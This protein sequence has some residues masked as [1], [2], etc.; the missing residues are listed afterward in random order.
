MRPTR[1]LLSLLSLVA[2]L[3][4]NQP[5]L[6][7]D[8]EDDPEEYEVTAR[9]ARIS[10]LKGTA[11]LRRDGDTEWEP[12]AINFPLVEGDTVA[13]ARESQ[14]E[15]QLDARNFI[16]LSAESALK[17]VTLR[18]EGV[19]LS[20][21]SGTVSLRLAALEEGRQFF[22]VDAPK[23]TLAAE[24]T[25]LYRVDVSPRGLVKVTVRGGGRARI[26]SETSGFTLREGR[27]A[28]L[29]T[30][31][32]N[33]GDWNLLAAGAPDL[34]DVWVEER[35]QYLAQHQRFDTQYHDPYVWGSEDLDSYGA[36]NY[37]TDYGWLWRPH[38]SSISGYQ[39][40]APYRFGN[41]V[42]CPPYGWT[43]VGYEPWGWAPYHYGRWVYYNNHWAWCPR[44]SYYRQ[45]SWW[46]PALVA[47]NISF[48]DNIYWYPLSYHHRDP[49]ARSRHREHSP[50][51]RPD[52]HSLWR[53][54]PGSAL[55]VEACKLAVS[56]IVV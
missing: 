31:G 28:E 24:R 27:A 25:G 4:L 29:L 26:Y 12:A 30:G 10:H 21:V 22:E 3:L 46:R 44:S 5:T 32:E 49:H 11:N 15:I 16:R 2:F 42:W 48:G 36:W 14:I 40:W 45:R 7:S 19:A 8:S 9:V 47:F 55:S 38:A 34:W 50:R 41:W 54:H 53:S 43:W 1:R 13:T 6:A 33:A 39:E 52:Y 35:E 37:T 56:L 23:A 18:E 17:I 51:I 20:I